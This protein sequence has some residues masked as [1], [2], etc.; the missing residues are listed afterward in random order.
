MK[1]S[2]LIAPLKIF[3]SKLNSVQSPSRYVGGEFGITVKPHSDSDEY[4]NF[5]V[6]F[7]DLY[8]IAMS[9][10]AVKIIYNG[11]NLLPNV[12]CERVFAPDVDFENLLKENNVPLYTIETG[13]PLFKT[14]MIGFSI[15]YEL[16]ITEVLAMLDSGKVHLLANER[17]EDEPI[18]IAGGCGVTNPAPFSD[19]FDAFFIGEAEPALFNL[20][21]DLSK[22]KK[23][24]ASRKELLEFIESKNFIWTKKKHLEKKVARRAV[25]ADFGLVPSVS[26]WFPLP[27]S[28]P[29]QDHGVVEIMRGCPNGCRFCHAG[30]YYRPMRVKNKNLIIEEIDHL[31][32]DAGYREVSLNSLSSADF[33]EVSNLLDILN[34]RYKGFNVSFQLPSLKV[35]AVSLDILEKLSKIR[36]SGLTFAVETP[37]EMWQLSLNKEVYASHLEEIIKEA[38][39]RGWSSAKF[40][41]MVGLPLGDYFEDRNCAP[42]AEGSEEKAIVDFLLELQA[43]T[44]IQCNV[45]V[46]VFIPKPH[47]PYERV[48]QIKPEV[49]EEKIEYIFKSLPRGKFKMGRHNYNATI[50]EGLLSRGDFNAGKVIL[51]AYK[52]GVRFDAWDDYLRKDFPLWEEAFSEADFNVRD[53]IFHDWT[54]E[55]LPWNSVS[56]GPAQ[57]FY[58]KEW[59]KSQPLSVEHNPARLTLHS[60]I[61]NQQTS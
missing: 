28:K 11:L 37:E 20:V 33:P 39:N 6:A 15:G 59:Q 24:G 26:G 54:E 25:Q 4:F 46:G 17:T 30:I 49:A 12:R 51:N 47:T 45:N 5:A 48:K 42:G 32:F 29:V 27:S 61:A 60:Q 44:K 52:K 3:G 1:N 40:Y 41:F 18:V 38:K 8:E 10:L 7:P 31:V 9:N 13:I 58:K 21:E 36:K 55:S 57:G 34:E 53:W 2:D 16:G 14:D 56:L 50:L 22:L 19:F 23:N 35:N 43:K